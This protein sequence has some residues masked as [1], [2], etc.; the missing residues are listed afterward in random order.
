MKNRFISKIGIMITL[1]FS[2]LLSFFNTNINVSAVDYTT[3]KI[4]ITDY[5]FFTF[6]GPEY[7]KSGMT[8]VAFNAPEKVNDIQYLIDINILYRSC[9][10]HLLW[11]WRESDTYSTILN[12][13]QYIDNIP[14]E[15]I[16][17]GSVRAKD[18]SVDIEP[19]IILGNI[20]DIKTSQYQIVQVNYD[21]GTNTGKIE[22]SGLYF[23]LDSKY[24]D[25]VSNY[26]Y[27]FFLPAVYVEFLHVIYIDYMNTDNEEVRWWVD[28]TLK[29]NYTFNDFLDS[30]LAFLE[31]VGNFFSKIQ[32]I[33]IILG[34][35]ILIILLFKI[36]NIPLK[37][38]G[39][40]FD[41]ESRAKRKLNKITRELLKVKKAELETIES[42]NKKQEK[43][44]KIEKK[45]SKNKYNDRSKNYYNF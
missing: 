32:N 15:W 19:A 16:A 26:K 6:D 35:I 29:D 27:Y 4:E 11:C 10:Q 14:V 39:L 12:K 18:E 22:N 8:L 3:E 20:S 41:N 7:Y 42:Q 21:D 9:E 38:V 25:S 37:F 23:K 17:G 44:N 28:T 40:G 30:V 43:E 31:K 34:V 24:Y 13:D 45:I 36:I 2:F 33:L 1:I 5:E